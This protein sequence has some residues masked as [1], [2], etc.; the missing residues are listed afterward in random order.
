MEKKAVEEH[1]LKPDTQY[2]FS[3]LLQFVSGV[4]PDT[5]HARFKDWQ[6]QVFLDPCPLFLQYCYIFS[7]PSLASFLINGVK[8]SMGT[9]KMMVEFFSVATSARVER[10]L[11]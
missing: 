1:L 9:G 11:N 10:N 8:R 3:Y 2:R 7:P 4:N 5:V 6:E